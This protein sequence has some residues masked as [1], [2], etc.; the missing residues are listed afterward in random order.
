M[1]G[2]LMKLQTWFYLSAIYNPIYS[3]YYSVWFLT[4]KTATLPGNF[5][6]RNAEAIWM[7]SSA[8]F[9]IL[10]VMILSREISTAD[11]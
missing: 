11:I 7:S 5:I 10:K 1:F 6:F 4:V 8:Q 2:K 9:S 3:I